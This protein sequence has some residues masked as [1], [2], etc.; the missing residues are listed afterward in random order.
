MSHP[1]H[2]SS[3]RLRSFLCTVVLVVLIE[4]IKFLGLSWSCNSFV[5][6]NHGIWVA[7]W[8]HIFLRESLIEFCW[9]SVDGHTWYKTKWKLLKM[10]PRGSYPFVMHASR[11]EAVMFHVLIM[12]LASFWK[13]KSDVP[14]K[15][16][17]LW[18]FK[19]CHDYESSTNA[20][21]P[22]II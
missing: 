22:L 4:S 15:H 20:H 21:L 11:C 19:C 9:A 3:I 17:L 14:T 6:M 5:L 16:E 7:W 18:C 1:Y 8:M 10:Q 13:F 12:M 2:G